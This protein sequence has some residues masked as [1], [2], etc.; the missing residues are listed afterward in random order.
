M[1]EFNF[2]SRLSTAYS[3]NWICTR[4]KSI[5]DNAKLHTNKHYVYN[6]DLKDFFPSIDQARV[7]AVLQ[8][9]VSNNSKEK[10]PQE[11]S[12]IIASL[13]CHTME[14][15]RLIEGQWQKTILN[16]L[17]QGAP[18][19]PTITNIICGRLDFYLT[20]VAKR[21]GLH[22]SRYADDITF[23]SL[24]N[25]FQKDSD[26]TKEIQRIITSQN[27]T[28]KESKTRLQKQGYR[29]EVTGLTV[30]ED[31]NV[32]QRYIKQLRMW[33]HFWEYYGYEKTNSDFTKK[34]ISDKGHV[35]TNTPNLKNVL[36]GKLLYLKMVKGENNELYLKLKKRFDYLEGNI[37]IPIERNKYLNEY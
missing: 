17:P 18:T 11:I 7:N 35:K 4:W 23:S 13:C 30:N 20:A 3:S 21:F 27:F 31:V 9:P 37:Q 1:L 15:E 33:L 8:L 32:N 19:S 25:V 6:I 10:L 14:V 36:T 12:F 24:H 34:Y 26:F 28:I 22:Y 29:Q 16:V 5:V 2:T